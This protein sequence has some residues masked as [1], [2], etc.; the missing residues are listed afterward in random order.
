MTPRSGK[1]RGAAE[2]PPSASALQPHKT[3]GIPDSDHSAGGKAGRGP[4][5]A[6]GGVGN[7]TGSRDTPEEAQRHGSQLDGGETEA[8]HSPTPLGNQRDPWTHVHS[9]RKFREAQENLTRLPSEGSQEH[10]L[11][12]GGFLSLP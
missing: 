8:Q 7:P 11:R 1:A 4:L 10:T 9:R 12:P 5:W 6:E 3:P 2:G